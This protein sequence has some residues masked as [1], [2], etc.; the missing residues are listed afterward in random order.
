MSS[1]ADHQSNKFVKLLLEGDSGTGKT[2][3]L[4]SLVRDLNL[5]LRILDFDNGLDILKGLILEQCPE[6]IGNVDYFTLVDKRTADAAE[7]IRVE[8]PNAFPSAIKLLDRWKSGKTDLGVPARWGPDCVLV[9]DSLTFFGA[10][11]YDFYDPLTPAG[12]SGDKDNRATY[13]A[14]Q[15]G[16]KAT[17]SLL[18][19]ADFQTNVIV[20]SHIR[21]VERQD[22]TVKGYPKSIGSAIAEEI[23][24]YFNTLCLCETEPGEKHYVKTISN[25]MVDLK[26]PRPFAMAKRYPVNTALARIFRV[27]TDPTVNDRAK[28]AEDPPAQPQTQPI[29]RRA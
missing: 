25:G 15:T 18:H 5:K 4:V 2:G 9:L 22:G 20:I 7:G 11:A 29:K 26:S 8:N 6:K 19:G 10:A 27:L 1:L 12:K 21:Y 28:T 3:S 17:L 16:V 13:Y 23:P 24:S 14:A